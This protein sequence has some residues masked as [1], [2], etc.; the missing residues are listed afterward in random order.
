MVILWISTNVKTFANHRE[1]RC[2]NAQIVGG[3]IRV[4]GYEILAKSNAATVDEA[5]LHPVSRFHSFPLSRRWNNAYL[6]TIDL[7]ELRFNVATK[8]MY[9]QNESFRKFSW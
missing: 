4:F 5:I 2:D 9:T 1:K 8:Y 7:D 3:F 6:L